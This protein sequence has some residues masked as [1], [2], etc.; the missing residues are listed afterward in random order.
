MSNEIQ[1][2]KN[3]IAFLNYVLMP[4]TSRQNV[5]A[6]RPTGMGILSDYG[7]IDEMLGREK[8]QVKE[9]WEVS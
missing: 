4:S 2:R 7:K 6:R 5:K 8:I 9:N 1:E 3:N